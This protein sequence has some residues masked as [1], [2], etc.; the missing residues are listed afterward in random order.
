ML[1]I[2]IYLLYNY[3]AMS[4]SENSKDY[5]LLGFTVKLDTERPFFKKFN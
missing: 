3:S 2:F 4:S 5:L 1:Y